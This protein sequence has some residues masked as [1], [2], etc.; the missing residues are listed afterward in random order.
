VRGFRDYVAQAGDG[1]QRVAVRH[2]ER[3]DADS[4]PA[5]AWP[6]TCDPMMAAGIR[7]RNRGR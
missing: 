5:E 3:V 1:P 6:C 7:F 2:V 4:P